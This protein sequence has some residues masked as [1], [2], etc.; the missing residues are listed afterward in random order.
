LGDIYTTPLLA[1]VA[2]RIASRGSRTV[3]IGSVAVVLLAPLALSAAA[4]PP[5][6]ALALK[7]SPRPGASNPA[8]IATIQVELRFDGVAT[9]AGEPLLQ[10]PLVSSNVDTVATV[11]Q[12]LDVRDAQGPLRLT[13]R[14][15]EGSMRP[16]GDA[17]IGGIARE[18]IT[19]RATSGT[20]AVR[21]AVPAE[22]SLPPRGPAPP[23]AFSNDGGGTSGAG[24][25]L[26]LLPPGD[27]AYR[28]TVSWD[29]SA[30]PR[31][32]RGLSS[33]GEGRVTAPEPLTA[34]RLRMAYYMAGRIGVWPAKVPSNGFFA[35][36][37]GMPPFDAAAVM[38][39]TGTLYDRYTVFFGRRAPSSYGVF[40]RYNPINAGGGVGL[41]RSFV[42]T[43]GRPGGPGSDVAELRMTLAH[44]MFHTFQP[45]IEDPAGLESS[46]FGEGLATFYQRRLP[47]RFGLISSQQFLKDL[48]VHA[49]RYY[50]SAMATVPNAEVPKRFWADTRIRTLPYDRGMLYFATI[51]DAVRKKSGGKRSLDDLMLAMLRLERGGRVLTNADWEAQLERE[52][53]RGAVAEFRAFLDGR[54]PVPAS[55]AFG[56]CFERTTVPLRR[57]VLGFDPAVLAEPKRIVRGLVAG[58]A[59]ATAGLRDGDEI[60][61]PV[62][63][64]GI[65][66]NQG[67]RL[68]LT[69]RRD[70]RTFPIVY[71]PRGETVAAYQWQRRAGVPDAGCAL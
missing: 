69:I 1:T 17:E 60:V 65:Q 48:N 47:L 9:K 52:L 31:G 49:G 59:A 15:A 67:E 56:P 11:I 71:L 12:G 44:E 37:Q 51:D 24:H 5:E 54:M 26:L 43:F 36:W 63:Q 6:P 22:A 3:R 50:T 21:Y 14:D 42:T 13:A 46:W 64:D 68:K 35:G 18:W 25:V 16:A 8:A 62:P 32:A 28:T 30:L 33:Y 41:D 20:L 61:V 40:L 34:G 2:T 23:F 53:G 45:Y 27:A 38:R 66:G 58:S 4:L 19:D 29:L 7:L 70:G 57:Y 55:D 39:W 10:M